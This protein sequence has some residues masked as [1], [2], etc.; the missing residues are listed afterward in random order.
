MITTGGKLPARFVIHAV[1]P[2][3]NEHHADEKLKDTTINSL[4]LIEKKI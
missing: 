3:F 4:K 2:K 1:G